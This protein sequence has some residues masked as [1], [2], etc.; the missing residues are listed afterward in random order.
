[1]MNGAQNIKVTTQALLV[2]CTFTCVNGCYRR[3]VAAQFDAGIIEYV[4]NQPRPATLAP[5]DPELPRIYLNTTYVA[6]TGTTINVAAGGDLQAAIN[7]AQPG[8][9]IM[10]QAG[11][12][13]TGN[14]KL[15]N[16]NGSSWIIIRSSTPD[17]NL[18]PPGTR[19][20]PDKSALLPKVISPNSD[21]AVTTDSAAHHYRF[22]GIEFGVAMG[23]G[24]YN[25]VAF[26]G[27]QTSL[28]QMPHDLIIDRCY[29]HGNDSD[30]AR[31]GVLLNSASTAVIDSYISNIHEDGADSQ[32]VCGWNGS[33]PFKI[34]N[35]YL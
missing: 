13:F 22:I 28:A 17:A 31:R 27:D 12:S 32:A 34:V 30:A 2:I 6:P 35:N 1:F 24:I 33:G 11:A 3:P 16:K 29:I 4:M 25:I 15:P 7:L 5:G 9:V 26:D 19:I 20:T 23:T 8:D 21:A 10:L 14:F 18:P